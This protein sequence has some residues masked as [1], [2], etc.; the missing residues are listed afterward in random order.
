[1]P[2]A[3]VHCGKLKPDIVRGESKREAIEG[4]EESDRRQRRV[5]GT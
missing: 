2:I 1:M 3:A 4:C 5:C